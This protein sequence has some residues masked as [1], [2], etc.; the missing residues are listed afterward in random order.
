LLER[1]VFVRRF[2]VTKGKTSR[3]EGAVIPPQQ[4]RFFRSVG[5]EGDRIV[6][7]IFPLFKK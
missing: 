2:G 4:N 6:P 5:N 7:F 3:A 1:K